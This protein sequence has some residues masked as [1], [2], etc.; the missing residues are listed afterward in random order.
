[1]T[2]SPTLPG[3]PTTLLQVGS[4]PG[5]RTPGAGATLGAMFDVDE[6]VSDCRAA[7]AEDEPRRAV[8][9]VLERALAR[10][11]E[12][13]DALRPREAGLTVLHGGPQLTIVQ[14]VWAPGMRVDPHDHRMWAAIGIYSGREDNSFYRRTPPAGDGRVL[15]ESGGKRLAVGDVLVL[16]DDAIHAV[17]NPEARLTGAIHIY[18]G[19]FVNDPRSQW[20][21]DLCEEQ[22]YGMGATRRT[23]AAANRAWR[24]GAGRA[25]A[26]AS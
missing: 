24:E 9:E 10:P 1:M 13:G 23:F 12:I 8:R 11:D 3:N 22:P 18:G 7:G 21:P 15:T 14:V 20:T 6:F 25:G 5:F 17:T 19:D 2:A 4:A 26:D 16:G